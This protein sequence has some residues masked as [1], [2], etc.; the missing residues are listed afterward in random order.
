MHYLIPKVIASFYSSRTTD[1]E[2]SK[3]YICPDEDKNASYSSLQKLAE[4]AALTELGPV[5]SFYRA[6][7]SWKLLQSAGH[8]TVPTA[9]RSVGST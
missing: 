3:T 1:N 4:L 6:R 8:L 7:V 5:E 9:P 2:K